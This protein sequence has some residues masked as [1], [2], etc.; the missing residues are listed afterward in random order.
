MDK[1]FLN[2][3]FQEAFEKIMT[4]F[5]SLYDNNQENLR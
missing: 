4:E 3:F 5:T 2:N 1:E